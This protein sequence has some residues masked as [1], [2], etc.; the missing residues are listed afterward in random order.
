MN[1]TRGLLIAL[2]VLAG[3]SGCMTGGGSAP[4]G[5]CQAANQGW[6]TRMICREAVRYTERK[7]GTAAV[8]VLRL[9]IGGGSG[10]CS[11]AEVDTPLG[12]RRVLFAADGEGAEGLWQPFAVSASF[13]WSQYVPDSDVDCGLYN[14]GLLSRRD[15]P[16]TGFATS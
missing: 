5:P 9:R 13:R 10:D 14:A 8:H 6:Q 7:L 11:I 2:A 15:L 16:K 1:H 3:S 12:A 4:A